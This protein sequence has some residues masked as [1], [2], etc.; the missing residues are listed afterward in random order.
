MA[1]NK[2]KGYHGTTQVMKGKL[3]GKTGHSDYFF[4]A[5]PQCANGQ[6]M[7]VLEY[8]D[9]KDAVHTPREEE[10]KKKVVTPFNL[11]FHLYCPVCQLEDYV[12]L[13]NSHQS[14]KL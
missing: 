11:A 3:T 5:C 1:F 8:E 2:G 4:F 7:R 6:V 14:F 9:R 13:D 12:K 10:K